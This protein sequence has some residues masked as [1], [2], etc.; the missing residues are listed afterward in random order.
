LIYKTVNHFYNG[1]TLSAQITIQKKQYND[2]EYRGA[3]LYVASALNNQTINYQLPS[4]FALEYHDSLFLNCKNILNLDGYANVIIRGGTYLYFNTI[5]SKLKEHK[6]E[7]KKELNERPSPTQQAIDNSILAGGGAI[8]VLGSGLFEA[9]KYED[10]GTV[11][12]KRFN[13]LYDMDSNKT[14]ILTPD[15]LKQI[16]SAKP[17]LYGLYV[18]SGSPDNDGAYYYYLSKLFGLE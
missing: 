2:A 18:R 10:G 7:V 6:Q 5:A 3:C 16:L 14:Y 13:Y 4:Y 17:D 12:S 8:A 1:N 9:V 15:F 11:S